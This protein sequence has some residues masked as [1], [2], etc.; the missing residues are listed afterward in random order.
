MRVDGSAKPY[1]NSYG[2]ET[3][4]VHTRFL[5]DELGVFSVM[6]CH[7]LIMLTLVGVMVE[8]PADGGAMSGASC[9]NT[10]RALRSEQAG[11]DYPPQEPSRAAIG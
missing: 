11:E 6:P 1:A 10:A 2:I 5:G 8:N 9:S 3:N 7:T 4:V